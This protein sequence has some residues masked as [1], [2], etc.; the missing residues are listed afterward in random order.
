MFLHKKKIYIRNESE[1]RAFLKKLPLYRSLLYVFTEFELEGSLHG[2]RLADLQKALNIKGKH[3]R[4]EFIY[5]RSCDIIDEYNEEHGNICHYSEDGI[6]EDPK[7]RTRVNGCCWYCPLQSS[8][9]CTSRNLSCKFFFC[10]HMCAKFKPLTVEDIDLL[11]MFNRSRRA[12]ARENYFVRRETCLRIL[13]LGSYLL[14]C[15]YSIIKL[16]RIKNI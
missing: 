1:Y 3:R 11:R 12:I 4:I 14:Y 7:H 13:N 15:V 10:D 2:K 9:G 8:T 6:C 16:F 5:D